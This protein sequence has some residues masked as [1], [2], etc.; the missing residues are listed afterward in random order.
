ML[1]NAWCT[2][3]TVEEVA[4]E[5]NTSNKHSWAE[6]VFALDVHALDT[7]TVS[8]IHPTEGEKKNPY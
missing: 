7:T 5:V 3:Q 2:P 1:A 8:E 4:E 6:D